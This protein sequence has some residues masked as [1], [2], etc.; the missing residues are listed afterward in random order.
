ME[1]VDSRVLSQRTLEQ[2]F[3]LASLKQFYGIDF[4]S[5]TT[6]PLQNT[7]APY[8]HTQHCTTGHSTNISITPIP[9]FQAEPNHDPIVQLST[10]RHKNVYYPNPRPIPLRQPG[11]LG[12]NP[13][14]GHEGPASIHGDLLMRSSARRDDFGSHATTPPNWLWSMRTVQKLDWGAYIYRGRMECSLGAGGVGRWRTDL[15]RSGKTSSPGPVEL[16]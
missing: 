14:I 5:A 15:S 8:T 16:G 6:N 9:V 12:S 1:V 11:P 13:R 7:L 10:K 4:S 2:V 3:K